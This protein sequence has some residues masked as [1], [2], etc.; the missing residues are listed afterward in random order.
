MDRLDYLTIMHGGDVL[1]VLEAQKPGLYEE[2]GS[3]KHPGSIGEWVQGSCELGTAYD[4]RFDDLVLA[5]LSPIWTKRG[6]PLDGRK[7]FTL[8]TYPD[9]KMP[10][11]EQFAN[12]K[13]M[14]A[15]VHAYSLRDRRVFSKLLRRLNLSKI[16]IRGFR[17]E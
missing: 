15:S 9:G 7:F 12:A 17:E 14:S 5:S 1:G 8:Y 10:A 3:S 16:S 6:A 13:K 2:L 11:P 4:L